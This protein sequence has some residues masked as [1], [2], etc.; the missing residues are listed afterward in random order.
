MTLSINTPALLFP[1]I[2]FLMLVYGNRFLALANLVRTLHDRYNKEENDR[3]NIV[4]QIKNIRTRLTIIKFMQG[5]SVC[6][7]LTS[8]ICIYQIFLE[9]HKT[10]HWLFAFSLFLIMLSMFLSF[11]E[12]QISTKAIETELSDIEEL[13]KSNVI[14][15]YFK[16]TFDKED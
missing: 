15:D 5:L 10:A 13:D 11:L 16:T 2:T 8:M 14:V 4:K 7:F 1:A 12:I 9:H 3:K 6:G